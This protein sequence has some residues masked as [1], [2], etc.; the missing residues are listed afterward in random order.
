MKTKSTDRK[1]GWSIRIRKTEPTI[2]DVGDNRYVCVTRFLEMESRSRYKTQ[3]LTSM[4]HYHTDA[5]RN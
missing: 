2:L 1:T 4:G 3:I 5:G